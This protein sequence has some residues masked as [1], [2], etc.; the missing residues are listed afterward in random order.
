LRDVDEEFADVEMSWLDIFIRISWVTGFA[1][2]GLG[3]IA[4]IYFQRQEKLFLARQQKYAQKIEVL[5][6]APIR[7]VMFDLAGTTIDDGT[8]VAD[9]LYEAAAEFGIAPVQPKLPSTSV[10]TRSI[11]INSSL[12]ERR[13]RE[14]N[15]ADFEKQKDPATRPR[16]EEIFHRYTE[17][18]INYLP[19]GNQADARRCGD[20]SLAPSARNKGGHRHRLSP[21]CQHGDH[22]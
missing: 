2:I 3:T 16:A 7:M 4:V 20:F 6:Q 17:I 18:M 9:C 14:V 10:P 12:P 22:G 15:F 1:T 19:P 13:G 11:S 21:R 5:M 8:A